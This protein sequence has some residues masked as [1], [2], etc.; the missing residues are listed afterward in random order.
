MMADVTGVKVAVVARL[1]QADFTQTGDKG[2]R[3]AAG[4]F[5][6]HM[7][8]QVV[9]S[10]RIWTTFA[11]R[12]NW[13]WDKVVMSNH[14][15]CDKGCVN[16][17]R[18]WKHHPKKSR[19]SLQ[20]PQTSRVL[21]AHHDNLWHGNHRFHQRVRHSIHY[22]SACFPKLLPDLYWPPLVGPFP[23]KLGYG[24]AYPSSLSPLWSWVS[25]FSALE[26]SLVAT[27]RG[28]C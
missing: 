4:W 6:G 27:Q 21:V 15:R 5:L 12:C 22:E 11:S 17:S 7:H 25:P 14:E 19:G 24:V 8:W 13:Q 16:T 9:R 2:E 3:V 26:E 18:S 28:S 10:W 1:L 23:T 20:F